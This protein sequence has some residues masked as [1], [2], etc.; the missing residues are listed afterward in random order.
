[1]AHIIQVAGYAA[2]RG[3]GILIRPLAVAFGMVQVFRNANTRGPFLQDFVVP[4]LA[5]A[6][7]S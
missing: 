1:M 4:S 2:G 3:I 7:I 6:V 5:A